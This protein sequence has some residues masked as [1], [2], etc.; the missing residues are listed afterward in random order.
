MKR[1]V[2]T[3]FLLSCFCLTK[4][5]QP[6]AWQALTD[7][8]WKR[9]FVQSLGGYYDIANFGASLE[10]L[11]NKEIS[12]KGFYVPIDMEGTMFA[13]SKSPSSTCFFCGTGGIETVIEIV[14]KKGHQELRRIKIDKY[15][16]LKGTL[17]LNRDDPEHLMYLL[18]DAEL[19]QVIK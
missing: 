14:V 10:A 12:I 19:I 3:L 6:I 9:A 17:A 5:Q 2:F 8:T 13:L 18:K 15:I 4:A 16:E 11:N 7:V 1:I